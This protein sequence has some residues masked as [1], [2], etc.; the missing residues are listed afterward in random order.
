MTVV[1]VLPLVTFAGRA[2]GRAMITIVLSFVAG[3]S[4]YATLR[5]DGRWFFTIVAGTC[6]VL[7]VLNLWGWRR[8]ESNR[9]PRP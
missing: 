3:Q 4:F 7:S 1:A 6:A 5:E 9:S 2:Y 8:T